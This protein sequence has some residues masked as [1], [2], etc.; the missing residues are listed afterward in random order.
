MAEMDPGKGE[1]FLVVDDDERLRERLAWA[2]RERGF[3]ARS[4][5][6]PDTP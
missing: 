3:E 2:L 6:G 1:C 4:A 5:A